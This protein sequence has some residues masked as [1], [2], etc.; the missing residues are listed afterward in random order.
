M[1][2]QK[3]C[4]KCKGVGFQEYEAG[5]IQVACSE[6]KATGKIQLEIPEQKE[7]QYFC[8]LC[9]SSHKEDS[10]MGKSHLQYKAEEP[11]AVTNS[12]EQQRLDN[13]AES[14]RKI[15]ARN[16]HP[17]DSGAGPDNQP[18]G[19]TNTSK[20]K[21]PKKSKATKKARARTS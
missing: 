13:I 4:P 17:S 9:E 20:P 5:L 10:K 19:S 7:G 15:E 3:D 16:D 11:V 1:L 14:K 18:S 2:Y 12:R 21:E 8:V 6:C